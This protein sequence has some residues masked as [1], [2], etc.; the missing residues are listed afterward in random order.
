MRRNKYGAGEA[1][2][3]LSDLKALEKGGRGGTTLTKEG[4]GVEPGTETVPG[5]GYRGPRVPSPVLPAP[6]GAPARPS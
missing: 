2:S 3:P 1:P 5:P 4:G 6:A